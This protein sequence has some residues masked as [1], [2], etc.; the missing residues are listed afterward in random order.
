MSNGSSGK[1]SM[2]S[3]DFMSSGTSEIDEKRTTESG[4]PP[5]RTHTPKMSSGS[6]E[7]RVEGA[8]LT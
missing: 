2:S 1:G 6:A 5:N 3:G 4:F 8:R 7:E